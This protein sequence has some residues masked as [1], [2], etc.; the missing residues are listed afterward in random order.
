MTLL[1]LLISSPT[2]ILTVLALFLCGV[3]ILDFKR[4]LNSDFAR[5]EKILAENSV[6][7][8]R[9]MGE[10]RDDLKSHAETMIK[11]TRGLNGDML[12]VKES[13]FNLKQE[14]IER[15][16]NIKQFAKNLEHD[17]RTL[18]HALELTAEQFEEK[19]GRVI[20][21]RQ[22]L[23]EHYGRVHLIEKTTSKH[24]EWFTSVAQSLKA[25][26]DE[27]ARLKKGKP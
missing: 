10:T 9:H 13:L 2:N 26:S 3:L 17:A 7:L 1:N 24:Q 5:F 15:L 11:A 4:R 12:K 27:L 19:F 20:L 6:L 23:E 21:L 25:H 14:M 18:A 22:E 16:E 8:T